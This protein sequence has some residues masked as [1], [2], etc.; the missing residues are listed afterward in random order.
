MTL[1][2]SP[3]V[4]A[5]VVVS[6]VGSVVSVFVVSLSSVVISSVVVSSV[7]ISSD[8]PSS[9]VLSSAVTSGDS[10]AH[11]EKNSDIAASSTASILFVDIISPV[12]ICRNI[13]S[14]IPRALS[15]HGSLLA[16]G[17]RQDFSS[18]KNNSLPLPQLSKYSQRR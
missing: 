12:L 14:F 2:I 13:I 10:Q 11:D 16:S 8:V 7:V 1:R 17:P 15:R 3:S 18:R 5:A 4:S 9:E 6:D